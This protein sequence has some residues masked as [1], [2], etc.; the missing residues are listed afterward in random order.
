MCFGIRSVYYYYGKSVSSLPDKK[1]PNE[2]MW[3]SAEKIMVK[4]KINGP[5][6]VDKLMNSYPYTD[7]LLE[8]TR[9]G[10]LQYTIV[11]ETSDQYPFEKLENISDR[12][13]EE[14]TYDKVMQAI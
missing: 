7:F 9:F 12:V 11:Y 4:R 8:R 6:I 3:E 13:E 14:R 1:E 5:V 10:W 2:G